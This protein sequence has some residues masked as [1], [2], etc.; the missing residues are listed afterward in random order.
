MLEQSQTTIRYLSPLPVYYIT[1]PNH[2]E[3][4]LHL[5]LKTA[6]VCTGA[7]TNFGI[8]SNG[9]VLVRMSPDW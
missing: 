2:I 8:H 7:V 9:L 3:H 5:K 1:A 4:F 6:D